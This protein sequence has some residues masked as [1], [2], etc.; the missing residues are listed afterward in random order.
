MKRAFGFWRLG[1]AGL[2]GAL[3]ACAVL[4]Q[5][6]AVPAALT[7][8]R[9]AGLDT[10]AQC[11]VL[12]RPLDPAQPQGRQIELHYLVVP[13]LARNKKPDPVI[14][15]AGG[16]GQSAIAL[17]GGAGRLLSRLG[18]RRDL[19]FIDQ[20]G[21]G[22]SAP[23]VCAER[24]AT[25][26]LALSLDPA[27]QRQRLQQCRQQLQALPHGD[28]RHFTTW[29]AMQD[30]EA[31]RQA[32]GAPQVN[33]V[34]GSYGTRAA[35]EFQRQFPNAVRRSILDGVAPP[36][37][38]LPESFGADSQAALDAVFAA[39]ANEPA[40]Q[41]QHP[42]LRAQWL[43]LLASLPREVVVSHPVTGRSERVLLQRDT[44][45]SLV[46][47][48]TYRPALAAALP[49]AVSQAAGGQFTAL[50]GLASATAG[51][52][53][54]ELA[55]G[56][57]FSVVCAEDY[58][59]MAVPLS[60]S[61]A[62]S[63]A[64]T[65]PT[66]SNASSGLGELAGNPPPSEQ[67]TSPDFGNSQAQIYRQACAQWPQG[68]VPPAFYAVPPARSA[69]LLLSGGADPATPP[70]HGERTAKALGPLAKHVQVAHAG[71]GVMSLPCLRDVLF[72][73][74]D[75]ADDAAALAVDA[76]CASA[77]PRPGAFLGLLPPA[78]AATPGA[79]P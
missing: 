33:L 19:V 47:G 39:C 5:G 8:C 16:P 53:G 30:A 17:A 4:A 22:R 69:T 79:K 78:L 62:V 54:M 75:A 49:L 31:V 25:E 51:R 13:A 43:G 27:L 12:Q 72:R 74:I 50:L 38:V 23:L 73:F 29:V 45:L 71:H 77:V 60:P 41:A 14:F 10:T 7:P 65:T 21:T 70:R 18:Q 46:R 48:P 11:G 34:G 56:M 32:L 42:Q 63:T 44:V 76:Q 61:A 6:T 67:T 36:D 35:L 1:C 58:P 68:A 59:R 37:M 2:V 66:S 57:H 24:P 15:F 9:V 64:P 26:P 28:L 20:R 52:R 55:E 40:C 3:W